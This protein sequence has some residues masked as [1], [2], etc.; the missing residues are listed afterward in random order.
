MIAVTGANGHLGQ[1]VIEGL[2]ERVPANQIIAAVRSPEKASSFGTLGVQVREADYTRPETLSTA[3]H[4]VKRVL[5]ISA[6]EVSH[7]FKL[8]KAVIDAAKE[9]GVELFV[10]TTSPKKLDGIV[11]EAARTVW[12]R[13]KARNAALADRRNP[14]QSREERPVLSRTHGCERQ[15]PSL[16]P[17]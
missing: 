11:A 8:H 2:V 4:G 7:R 12:L 5:L 9:A 17:F 10:Y 3:L 14:T 15:T 13:L 16:D 6:A 1:L